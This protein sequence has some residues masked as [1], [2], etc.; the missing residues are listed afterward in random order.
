MKLLIKLLLFFFIAAVLLPFTFLK[1]QDGKALM[2]FSDIALP[3]VSFSDFFETN[4]SGFDDLEGLTNILEPIKDSNQIYKWTD[5]DG[6]LH[7]SSSPPAEDISY[8]VKDYDPNQNVVQAVSV[9]PEVEQ[10]V[11]DPVAKEKTEGKT[12][13]TNKV[14]NPYSVKK[15]ERL[16][17]DAEGL[18]SLL[19]N[20]LKKQQ[21]IIDQ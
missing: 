16:F 21:T 1:G 11:A 8:T 13:G 6:N 20:R 4:I 10:L 7:F 12:R 19:T 2:N 3:D 14:G 17:K 5:I 18:E 9:E 15:V